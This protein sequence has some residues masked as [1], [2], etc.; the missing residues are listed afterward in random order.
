M[1]KGLAVGG[2]N[3]PLRHRQHNPGGETKQTANV[4]KMNQSCEFIYSWKNA[5]IDVTL[6]RI[7]HK[8]KV[9]R[10]ILKSPKAPF[11]KK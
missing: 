1:R 7:D 11:A 3:L 6:H 10:G 2:L 9:I 8:H 5:S 4:H